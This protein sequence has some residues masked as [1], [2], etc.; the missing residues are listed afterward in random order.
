MGITLTDKQIKALICRSNVEVNREIYSIRFD[1]QNITINGD[2]S[3][4][5]SNI[6]INEDIIKAIEE[7][8]TRQ[9]IEWEYNSTYSA[10]CD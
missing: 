1:A 6:P 5:R 4:E 7:Y 8:S 9:N 3:I 10:W 2:W